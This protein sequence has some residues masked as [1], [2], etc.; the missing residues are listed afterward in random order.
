[1]RMDC[2]AKILLV[3]L[4]HN[5]LFFFFLSIGLALLLP[6]AFGVSSLD[7]VP[8]GQPLEMGLS[9]IGVI[10]LVP[11]FSPEQN[12]NIKDLVRSRKTNY[13][14]VIL[15]RVVYSVV[16]IALIEGVFVLVMK[17]LECDVTYKHFLGAFGSALLL[18]SVGF[19]VAGISNNVTAGYMC[20]ILYFIANFFGKKKLLYFY[21]FSI[22][23]AEFDKYGVKFLLASGIIMLT[24][25]IVFIWDRRK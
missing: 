4:K 2:S 9:L 14:L 13:L 8:A 10:M 22:S 20:S 12:E 25:L 7:A 24:L 6:V 17:S 11:I 19:L 21:L 3:N 16:S 23:S 18:G 15:M 1:M 5:F